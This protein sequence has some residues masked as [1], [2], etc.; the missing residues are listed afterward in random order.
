MNEVTNNIYI[1]RWGNILGS[2]GSVLSLFIDQ[3]K[4]KKPITVTDKNM[5]RFWLTIED[6]VEFVDATISSHITGLFW[7]KFMKCSL[8][9]DLI[10]ETANI[11]DIAECQIVE[12]GLRPGEK[13]HETI[14]NDI[15]G[16]N[17]SSCNY[18][19]FSRSELNEVLYP[20]VKR[21]ISNG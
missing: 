2:T 20:I 14:D 21:I 15:Y 19:S 1:F 17:I 6:A 7:P 4:N 8:L 12:V 13:I 18:N 9:M 3:L 5:T 10:E 16:N 11:L